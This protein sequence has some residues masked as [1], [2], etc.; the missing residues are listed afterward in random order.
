MA[1]LSSPTTSPLPVLKVQIDAEVAFP[2]SSTMPGISF[3]QDTGTPALFL[4]FA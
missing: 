2:F 3:L 1:C 4:L